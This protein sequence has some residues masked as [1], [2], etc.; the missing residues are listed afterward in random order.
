LRIFCLVYFEANRNNFL[1]V[2]FWSLFTTSFMKKV[3]LTYL[4]AWQVPFGLFFHCL[5]SSHSH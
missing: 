4:V 3:K 1:S 5:S 2:I